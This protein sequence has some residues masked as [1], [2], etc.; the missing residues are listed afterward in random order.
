VAQEGMVLD[1]LDSSTAAISIDDLGELNC[2]LF[3]L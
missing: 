3:L 1:V 2:L